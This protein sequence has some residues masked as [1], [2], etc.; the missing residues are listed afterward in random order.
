[1]FASVGRLAA[2]GVSCIATPP[3]EKCSLFRLDFWPVVCKSGVTD[4]SMRSGQMV[5]HRRRNRARIKLLVPIAIMLVAT[6]AA[7][8]APQSGNNVAGAVADQARARPHEMIDLIA[9]QRAYELNNRV[10]SAADEMLR[11]TTQR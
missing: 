1:M 6:V 3:T 2:T 5:P 4:I 7:V 10:I 8:A 9:S 11:T